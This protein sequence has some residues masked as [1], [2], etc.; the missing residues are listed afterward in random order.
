[1][2]TERQKHLIFDINCFYQL[3]SQK[4]KIANGQPIAMLPELNYVAMQENLKGQSINWADK[5]KELNNKLINYG[6][7]DKW[8]SKLIACLDKHI[9][10][11]IS[12]EEFRVNFLTPID[13]LMN[14][15]MSIISVARPDANKENVAE[16]VISDA[17]EQN[18]WEGPV[19][20]QIKIV[21]TLTTK[22]GFDK[23]FVVEFGKIFARQI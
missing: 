15:I 14:M 13:L 2:I 8:L 5:Y 4:S 16:K 1:M 12:V 21:R 7:S 18:Y 11:G 19:V 6:L 23:N 9:S 10:N 22:L 20:Q 3:A 17:F